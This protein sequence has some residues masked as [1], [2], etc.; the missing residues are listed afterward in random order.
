MSSQ[1]LES[2]TGLYRQIVVNSEPD[3][4][5]IFRTGAVVPTQSADLFSLTENPLVLDAKLDTGHIARTFKHIL[6]SKN[7]K[8]Q[9]LARKMGYISQQY[10]SNLLY[11]PTPWEKCTDLSKRLYHKFHTWSQ[12]EEDVSSL[13]VTCGG[14]RSI[15]SMCS[16]S[17]DQL[18]GGM[19]ALRLEIASV[20]QKVTEVLCQH[21]ITKKD[22]AEKFLS[23]G[24]ATLCHSLN[25]PT[26]WEK[27]KKSRKRLY[28]R[29]HEWSTS[30]EQIELFKKKL[31]ENQI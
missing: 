6:A 3:V 13:Q 17:N 28:T 12:S 11:F 25:H 1:V 7:I 8:Q 24:Y 20:A 5:E 21:A 31:S 14:T 30:Q 16:E 4:V 22:F 23:I 27:C 2:P 29:M 18:G 10:F 9:D 26:A 19:D 15:G